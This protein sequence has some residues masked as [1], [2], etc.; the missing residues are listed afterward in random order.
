LRHLGSL[1]TVTCAASTSKKRSNELPCLLMCPSRRRSPLGSFFRHKG[2]YLSAAGNAHQLA[3]FGLAGTL[4]GIGG[5]IFDA[6][7][8]LNLF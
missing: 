6:A 7:D 5:G 3:G 1:S 2:N 4:G 8:Y